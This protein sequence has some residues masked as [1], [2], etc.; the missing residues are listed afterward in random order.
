MLTSISGLHRLDKLTVLRLNHNL[1][2]KLG[3]GGNHSHGGGGGGSNKNRGGGGK[4]LTTP[5][6]LR[7]MHIL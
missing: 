5:R 4:K 2:R 3:S 6:V 7:W 1:I